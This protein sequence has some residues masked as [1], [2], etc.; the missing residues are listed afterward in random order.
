MRGGFGVGSDLVVEVGVDR[1]WVEVEGGGWVGGV[2]MWWWVK[3]IIICT[4]MKQLLTIV[5]T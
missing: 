4:N 3:N 2:L 5:Q 1:G